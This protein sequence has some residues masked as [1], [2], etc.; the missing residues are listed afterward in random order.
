MKGKGLGTLLL[1]RI[2]GYARTRGTRFV[3]GE[4]LRENAPMLALA[5]ANGF[6]MHASDDPSVIAVRLPLQ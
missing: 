6:E 1:A 5:R 2:I 3:T 4:I